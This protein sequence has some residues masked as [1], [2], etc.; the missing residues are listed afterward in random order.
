MATLVVIDM[1]DKFL[2]GKFRP[3]ARRIVRLIKIAKKNRDDII[4]VEYG[5]RYAPQF[6]TAEELQKVRN[7]NKTIDEITNAVE[8]YNK[9]YKTTKYYDDGS[10]KVIECMNDNHLHGP[11]IACGVNTSCCVKETVNGLVNDF[12]MDVTVVAN[13]CANVFR[14]SDTPYTVFDMNENLQV[15]DNHKDA[16]E[17]ITA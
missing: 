13:C 6:I 12:G 3:L 8:S 15:V 14:D 4:L 7:E 17:L 5:N 11:I 9:V 1:Q 2:G 10:D 16:Y